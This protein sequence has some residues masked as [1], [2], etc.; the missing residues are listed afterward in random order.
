MTCF[1]M[2]LELM[3]LS[4]V[5]RTEVYA[6]HAFIPTFTDADGLWHCGVGG[7]GGGEGKQTTRE[8]PRGRIA[9]ET[10]LGVCAQIVAHGVV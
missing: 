7:G 8:K 10:S 5:I 9:E 4:V 1:M 3:M 6:H 2:M